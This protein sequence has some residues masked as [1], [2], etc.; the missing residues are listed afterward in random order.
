M[1]SKQSKFKIQTSQKYFDIGKI[2]GSWPTFSVCIYTCFI[3]YVCV[4][5]KYKIVHAPAHKLPLCQV[6]EAKISAK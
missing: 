4:Y 1:F 2:F 3:Q 5:I 6:R